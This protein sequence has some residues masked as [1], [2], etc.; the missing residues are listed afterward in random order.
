[1]FLRPR[2]A[3]AHLRQ[4]PDIGFDWDQRRG[5]PFNYFCYGAAAVEVELDVLTGDH[6]VRRADMVMDVGASLN[7]AIDIGQVEGAHTRRAS[8]CCDPTFFKELNSDL[9]FPAD[10]IF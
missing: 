3:I 8:F 9:F 7:P 5:R 4:T 10:S 6:V 2:R 1:M